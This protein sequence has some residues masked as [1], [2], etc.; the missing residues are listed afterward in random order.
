MV[1]LQPRRRRPAI[2]LA[3]SLPL[4]LVGA[5]LLP[6]PWSERAAGLLILAIFG[7]IAVLCAARVCVRSAY[8][9]ELHPDR[10]VVRDSFG[11][12]THDVA[13]RDIAEL[14]PV[15]VYTRFGVIE[16][17]GWRCSPRQPRRTGLA[18][19]LLAISRLEDV[20]GVLP[21]E[22]GGYA[23]TLEALLAASGALPTHERAAHVVGG[24]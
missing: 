4:V 2:G 22:Y 10:F 21:D 5:A 14:L 24:H 13:W 8:T 9:T 19:K 7:P 3:V 16:L 6:G 15:P 23:P 1:V 12:V 11:R 17:V 18:R 20:D